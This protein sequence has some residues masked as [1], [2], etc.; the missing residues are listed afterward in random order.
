MRGRDME[1]TGS[2]DQ[3]TGMSRRDFLAASFLAGATA[4]LFAGP[5]GA[6]ETP[7]PR[8]KRP[9]GI[10]DAMWACLLLP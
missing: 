9:P 3:V 8:P 1:R 5:T 6:G 10:L 2:W 4:G 7:M